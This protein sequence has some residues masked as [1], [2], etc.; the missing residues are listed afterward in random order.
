M[1]QEPASSEGGAIVEAQVELLRPSDHR[2]QPFFQR[3]PLLM[4]VGFVILL[5]L[6]TAYHY[7]IYLPQPDQPH[8]LTLLDDV[9]AGGI[10]SLIAVAGLALGR[11]LLRPFKLTGFSWLE[12]GALAIGLGWGILSLGVLALGLAQLLYAWVLLAGLALALLVSWREVRQLWARL[13]TA[14]WYRLPDGARPRGFFERTLARLALFELGLLLTHWL[15]P[16]PS[17]AYDNYQYHW[18]VPNLYLL[19]HAIYALPGWAHANFPF[20]SEM[21]NTLALAFQAP[22]A[23]LLVQGA[24]GLLAVLLIAG[25]LYRHLGRTA[26]WLGVSL[27]LACPLFVDLLTV[28]YTELALTYAAVASLVVLLTWLEQP[29]Q[30][31]FRANLRLVL[32][33]GLFIGTGLAAK[34]TEGQL[35]VGIGLLLTGAVAL[36]VLHAWQHGARR[37]P[38]LR[39]ALLALLLYGVGV[40][41]PLLPWLAKDWAELGNPIYPFIWGGPGWDAARTQVGVV[42]FAHFGPHGPLWQRLLL[43]FFGL[44]FDT[45]HTGEP[46]LIP[47]NYLLLLAVVAPLALVGEWLYRRKRRS[48]ESGARSAANAWR[49]APWLIVAGAAYLAWVL[50]NALVGRYAMPWLLLLVVPV[51]GMLQCLLQWS[52]DWLLARAAL[53]AT[54]LGLT[55]A[56]GVILSGLYWATDS[57]LGLITGRVSLQQWEAQHIMEPAYWVMIKYVNTQIPR[58]AKVLLLGRGTGYFMEGR[59]Y[60]ADSAEDWIPYLETEGHT[61]TG[62]LA[63]L[64]QDGFRYVIYEEKTLN[65][66]I[67]T[68]ENHYLATFLPAFRQFLHDSL[69]QVWSY[70]NYSVYHV[71]SP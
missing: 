23:A 53:Q 40:V 67:Q 15:V 31:G 56:L 35:V 57:P 16:Y 49:L 26:A 44:F 62:I 17:L 64:Q 71:P 13:T 38:I 32:L 63:L 66:V 68:Y 24:F 58:Q 41:A 51:A 29:E 52:W 39:R 30:A 47:P 50:S 4:L 14:R 21:L 70:Q 65:F 60:I 59:D 18:A 48:S 1:T 37:W 55:L 20:S 61:Q 27:S 25:Y 5:A 69:T 8:R 28:G 33:S 42:T 2:E 19:H 46:S 34:Y 3:R 7:A 6:A 10:F 11:L 54:I 12:R 36:S 22:V 9:F 43:A 45:N